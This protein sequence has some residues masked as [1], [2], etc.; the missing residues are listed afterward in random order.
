MV[1]CTAVTV[2]V[3]RVILA[4]EVIIEVGVE[5]RIQSIKWAKLKRQSSG[6]PASLSYIA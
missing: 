3:A 5:E 2:V 6:L 4:V 1:V